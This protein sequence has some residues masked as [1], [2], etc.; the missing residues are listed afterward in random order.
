MFNSFS[1]FTTFFTRAAT[2]TSTSYVCG[3]FS[4]KRGGLPFEIT[5]KTKK[6]YFGLSRLSAHDKS[7]DFHK[8]QSSWKRSPGSASEHGLVSVLLVCVKLGRPDLLY[9][10]FPSCLSDLVMLY[11]NRTLSEAKVQLREA[12]GGNICLLSTPDT[13][14]TFNKCDFNLIY[15]IIIYFSHCGLTTYTKQNYVHHKDIYN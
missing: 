6:K 7:L 12:K 9:P 1:T 8:S 11:C 4:S 10:F 15:N 3:S 13:L 14:S 5:V 2:I